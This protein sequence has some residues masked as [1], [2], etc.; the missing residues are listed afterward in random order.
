VGD[1]YAG[2][3]EELRLLRTDGITDFTCAVTVTGERASGPAGMIFSIEGMVTNAGRQDWHRSIDGEERIR[4]GAR[5]R[6]PGD[7]RIIK[8]FRGVIHGG[9]MLPAGESCRYSLDL[10]STGLGPGVY[11]LTVDLVFE[12]L[13]W[14]GERWGKPAAFTLDLRSPGDHVTRSVVNGRSYVAQFKHLLHELRTCEILALPPGAETV[15]SA[16]CSDR[17]FFDWFEGQYPGIR[18]HIGVEY[19]RPRPDDL[20]PHIT[21][22][23]N[24]V[25]D[26]HDIADACADLYFS[27]QNI[28]HLWP[29]EVT[30]SLLEAH[31]VLKRGGLAVIDS[32]NR[33]V[34]R[35]YGWSHWGH[36]VE[37]T[38]PEIIELIELAGFE[39]PVVRGIWTCVD[40]ADDT[41]LPLEHLKPAPR[42]PFLRRVAV[43]RAHPESSFIWWAEARKQDRRPDAAA[44]DRRVREI[45]AQAWPERIDRLTSEVGVITGEGSQRTAAAPA[46]SAGVLLTGPQMPLRAGNY[47][48]TF[49]LSRQTGEIG[50]EAVLAFCDIAGAATETAGSLIARCDVTG[51][52]AGAGD[53]VPI[54]LRF[55]L[56]ETRFSLRFRVVTRGVVGLSTRMHL[57]LRSV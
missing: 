27:G 48:V 45:F 38:V 2:L 19:Y 11:T 40:P 14:F 46:G 16:G 9:D 22:V 15:V 55:T 6:R 39:R 12:H 20:P 42:W 54:R 8:E 52:M 25:S 21:W 36:T 10:D 33:A 57:D 30:G 24:T 37:Y 49:H 4:V 51:A 50:G 7:G 29:E 13:F 35:R 56:D 17:S 41:T 43:A 18:S 1:G 31:R 32:P 44:L 26:L 34:T 5:L 28:E 53:Y 3:A 23:R 47:E